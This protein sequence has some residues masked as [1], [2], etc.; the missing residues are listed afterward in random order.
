MIGTEERKT[1]S[2]NTENIQE[3]TEARDCALQFYAGSE[4]IE[5]TGLITRSEAEALW[6]HHKDAFL[7]RCHRNQEAQMAIWANMQNDCD[8]RTMERHAHSDEIVLR[9]G[10]AFNLV[11]LFK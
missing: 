8:Y 7:R 4:L 5:D 3:S 10:N 2:E 6:E 1:M 11:P 9:H